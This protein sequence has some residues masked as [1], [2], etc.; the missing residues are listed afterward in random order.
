[1]D[2]PVHVILRF[3]FK[4]PDNFVEPKVTSDI[5]YSLEER[6]W[7]FLCS[8]PGPDQPRDILAELEQDQVTFDWELLAETLQIPLAQVFEAASEL[9]QKHMGRPLEL[10]EDSVGLQ[11]HY[12]R[13][14]I[15]GRSDTTGSAVP[16]VAGSVMAGDREA[17]EG[18]VV[19]SS[20]LSDGEGAEAPGSSDFERTGLRSVESLGRSEGVASPAVELST[21]TPRDEVSERSLMGRGEDADEMRQ[22]LIAEAMADRVVRRATGPRGPLD[23]I[24]EMP[25]TAH[26]RPRPGQPAAASS[27]RSSSFSDLSNN[28]L[29]ESAMQDA[30]LSEAMN[31]ST[32]MSSIL[33]SRMFP[34]TKKRR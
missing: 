31:G 26:E 15:A 32:V 34:W 24:E 20:V 9:F 21:V 16:Q 13:P 7:R 1:M 14:D 30:L 18:V 25:A 33:G 2:Q 27:S 29:T 8:L 6:V 11:P 10:L 5:E 22:S 3:P 4:R 12:V 23:T 17:A 19:R 28:S